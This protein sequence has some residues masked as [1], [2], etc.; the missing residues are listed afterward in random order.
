MFYTDE[1]RA[2]GLPQRALAAPPREGRFETEGWRVRKDGSRFWAMVVIDPIYDEDGRLERLRQGDARHHRAAGN[3]TSARA[4]QQQ[5]LASQ[6]MEAVGQLSGGIAH[7]FNNLLMIVLGNLESATRQARRLRNSTNLQRSLANAMRGAQRA[8]ALTSRLLA[9]SRGSPSI[10][11]RSTSTAT[12]P[13]SS[14]SCSARSA[15][16]RRSK[17]SADAGSGRRSR[18]EP[19]RGGP[20]QPGHQCAR[21]H[22]GRGQADPRSDQRLRERGLCA[23]NPEVAE[24]QYVAICV[25]DTGTGMAADVVAAP[26]SRSTP[27]RTSDT[28]P[29]SASARCT[30]S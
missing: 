28:G 6:K 23:P 11:S 13:A 27:P 14:T 7:D 1:D 15:N 5:L 17:S 21:C 30:A 29:A 20:R 19:A 25:T 3:A 26:S 9:F 22:A 2:A 16:S 4:A 12:S 10:R 8:A 18:P 24:G